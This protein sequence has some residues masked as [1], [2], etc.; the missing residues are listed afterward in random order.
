[1]LVGGFGVPA[2]VMR[3]LCLGR[4]CDAQA[5]TTTNTPYCSLPEDVR[6]AIARGFYDGRSGEI[7]AV[8]GT[9]PIVG[10][11]RAGTATHAVWPGMDVAAERVPLVFWGAGV[12]EGASIPDGVG[13]D[14]V[15]STVAD[16]IG[17]ERPHAQVRSGDTIDEVAGSGPAPTLVVEIVWKGVDSEDLEADEEAWP[18]LAAIMQ[19]GIGTPSAVIPSLPYDPAA[20][21]TTLG[22]G[23]VPSDHGIP[24]ALLRGD[25]GELVRAWDTNAP[26]NVIATMPDHL[27]ELLDEK[28]LI[29]LVGTDAM[30]R[31]LIGGRWYPGS[32]ID[33]ESMLTPKSS[34]EAQT[35]AVLR[36][37][38]MTPLGKDAVP[39]VLGVVQ[40]GPLEKLDES[41]GRI[42]NAA[43]RVSNASV[44][45]VVSATGDA[46]ADA[47]T[48]TPVKAS[49]VVRQ[50]ERAI[51]GRTAL[52]EAATPGQLFLDQKALARQRVSD[53]AVMK[54][55]L[56]LASPSGKPLMADAFPGIA[57]TFGKYC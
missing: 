22:T 1:M 21:L 50:L 56:E 8:T 18:E 37:L 53:D 16:L 45:V 28:P 29:A 40:H 54:P 55:L 12:S 24:G 9:T 3:T 57:V 49:M 38:E 7:L 13:L 35:D 46:D 47:S 42:V 25:N 43:Q 44:A 52:I 17:L 27:D 19:E 33:M 48:G 41:L 5:T 39:D 51:P 32:D 10:G 14:D 11:A 6:D 23:G 20:I 30:D 4:A 36:L 34:V 26:M 15:A 2:A 31:G